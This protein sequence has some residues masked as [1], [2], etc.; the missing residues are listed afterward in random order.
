MRAKSQNLEEEAHKLN[1]A[2]NRLHDTPN[3]MS[4]SSPMMAQS[5]QKSGLQK[6]NPASTSHTGLYG[7][8]ERDNW[9][10]SKEPISQGVRRI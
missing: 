5:D 1:A 10:L 4:N 3:M 2:L 9:L 7:L 8:N 6:A